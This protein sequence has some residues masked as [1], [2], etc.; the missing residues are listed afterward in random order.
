MFARSH[1][2]ELWI[3]AI[4]RLIARAVEGGGPSTPLTPVH[5][6]GSSPGLR[7]L[8]PRREPAISC[9]APQGLESLLCCALIQVSASARTRSASAIASAT[10]FSVAG[11]RAVAGGVARAGYGLNVRGVLP[12]ELQRVHQKLEYLEMVA[13]VRSDLI[14]F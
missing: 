6:N 5:R 14:A 4:D 3:P 9:M 10:I 7:T 2:F 8:G 1:G 13:L 12:L 11:T